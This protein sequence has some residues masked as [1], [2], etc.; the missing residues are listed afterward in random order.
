M[1]ADGARDLMVE[2]MT[3]D[4]SRMEPDQLGEC[5]NLNLQPTNETL[6]NNPLQMLSRISSFSQGQAIHSEEH[7]E[8]SW[9]F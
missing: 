2:M 7:P 1:I 6:P 3:L 5:S 8:A 9:E 4:S